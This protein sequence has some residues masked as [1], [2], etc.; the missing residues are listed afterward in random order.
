M[1]DS[2]DPF[3]DLVVGLR[4]GD[5]LVL[6]RFFEHYG[7][8]LERLAARRIDP[9]F[10][11][12]VGP[13]SIAQSVC[14]TFLRRAQ[15]GEFEIADQDSLWGLLCAIALTKVREKVRF[16]RRQKRALD[17]EVPLESGLRAPVRDGPSAEEEVLFTDAFDHVI[18]SL[19]EDERSI[20]D[21]RL[22]G[23]TQVAIAERLGMSERTVRR[24]MAQL[25]QRLLAAFQ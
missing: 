19:S 14:R 22:Q 5:P 24:I 16:H 6:A 18:G 15:G 25:E 21:L 23:E 3:D 10:R 11:R 1:A 7:P 17:R 8:A 9:G 2:E 13:E 12:R 4:T 20:V